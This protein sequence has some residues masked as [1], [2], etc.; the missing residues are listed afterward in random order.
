MNVQYVDKVASFIPLLI[1]A[2]YFLLFEGFQMY[3][4]KW[5]YFKDYWNLFDVTRAIILLLYI[6]EGFVN[7]VSDNMLIILSFLNLLSWLRAL[8]YLRLF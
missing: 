8:S 7:G 5:S 1:F 4:V 2:I 6:F 3:L